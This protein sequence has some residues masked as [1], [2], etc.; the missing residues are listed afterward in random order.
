ME[1]RH[2]TI[3]KYMAEYN[4]TFG[5]NIPLAQILDGANIRKH[6]LPTLAKY[7]SSNG[8]TK[9]CYH[10][11]MGECPFGRKCHWFT[12]HAPKSDVTDE[13]ATQLCQVIDPAMGYVWRNKGGGDGSAAKKQRTN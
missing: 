13:F 12:G 11:I 9:L 6:N 7:T 8:K 10:H 2:P 1:H 4:N 3:V 5:F